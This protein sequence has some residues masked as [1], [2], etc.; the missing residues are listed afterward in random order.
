MELINLTPFA[1]ERLILMNGEGFEVLLVVVKAT[2]AI[3]DGAP[4][5]AE[6]QEGVV[7]AD[8][9]VGEPGESSLRRAAETSLGK[10]A[11]DVV[12]TG[13]AYSRRDRP[14]EALVILD[15][16]PVR[17]AVMVRGD[18]VWEGRLGGRPSS[19]QAFVS[20]PLV[21]ERAFGGTDK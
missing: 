12:V 18:R 21:Y 11:A 1:A 13:S 6:V 2:Y 4:V 8:E 15:I 16:G 20:L 7:L 17:K 5:L 3:Q 19:P 9:Y 14:T 10:P